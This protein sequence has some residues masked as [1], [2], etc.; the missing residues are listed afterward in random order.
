MFFIF[1][2]EEREGK[3]MGKRSIGKFFLLRRYV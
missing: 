1:S 3:K 2:Y